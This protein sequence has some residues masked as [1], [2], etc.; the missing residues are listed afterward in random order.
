MRSS[1][2]RT[3]HDNLPYQPSRPSPGDP[4]RAEASGFAD[5][6][7]SVVECS[8]SAAQ[9]CSPRFFALPGLYHISR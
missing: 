4:C 8:I 5:G 2:H 7:E 9:P 6:C 3:K 1:R